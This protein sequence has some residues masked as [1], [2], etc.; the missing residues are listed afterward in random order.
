MRKKDKKK[1]IAWQEYIAIVFFMLIGAACGI[2]MTSNLEN[3]F[4]TNKS[5]TEDILLMVVEFAFMF[6]AI[7][8]HLIIH[9]GGHLIFGLLTGYKFSSFRIMSFM[10][11]K[12]EEGIRFRRLRIAG[13]GGQCLMNPPDFVDGKIP[14]VL[15]N[16]GGS[17]INILAGL[18]CL[19]FYFVFSNNDLFS[20]IMLMSAVIGFAIAIM[21]G[22]PM[23]MGTVDNDGYNAFSLTRNSSSMRAFWVQMKVNE[24]ISKGVRL[25]DMNE[26]WFKIPEDKDMKNSMVAT[27]AV[28]AANRLMDLHEFEEADNLMEHML[29][30]ESGI[31]GLHRNLL[32]CDR[33][34]IELIT[35]NRR[36]AIDRMLSKEQKNFMKQMKNFPSVIRTEYAYALLGEKDSLKAEE[37]KVKFEKC[38]KTYPYQSDIQ[39]ER[40][41]MEIAAKS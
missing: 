38:A 40:E 20:V 27:I 33:V 19:G 12:E 41:L 31:V 39:S 21:N 36:E 24:Q 15:Y 3:N 23:R 1:K 9:E 11:V 8:V 22:V 18:I 30:I 4:D 17:L 16:L 32:V 29:K 28:F 35:E 7:F 2:L 37:L 25:K 34:F 6:I 10:W 5:A 14:V 13:T 26:E